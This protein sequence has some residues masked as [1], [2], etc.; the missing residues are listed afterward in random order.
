[1]NIKKQMTLQPESHT[2]YGLGFIFLHKIPF[3]LHHLHI[4]N[5]NFTVPNVMTYKNFGD[6]CLLKSNLN[7]VE[8]H[9]K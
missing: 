9:L 7:H 6:Q 1:M 5:M 4:G 2:K 3:I 8:N